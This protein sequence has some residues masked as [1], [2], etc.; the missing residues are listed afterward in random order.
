[1]PLRPDSFAL[2]CLLTALVAIGPLSTDLY[3]PALPAIAAAFQA[4][5]GEVQL[6]LSVFMG[7]FAVSQLIYG[8][9]SDRF[10]RRPVLLGGLAVYV[11]AS[12]LCLVA[13]SIEQLI[14]ARFL[15]ALGGCAGP[16]LGRA[17]V[18]D[19]FGRD[20]AA[21]A[22]S[23]MALAM[24]VAPAVGP[25]LGGYLQVWAGWTAT[26]GVL[27]AIGL[28]LLAAVTRYLPETNAY[29]NPQATRPGRLLANYALLARDPAYRG[30]VATQTCTFAGIFA[31]ISGSSFVLV[32][33]VGLSPD[34][35]GLCFAIVVVGFMVGTFLSGRLTRRWGLDR[36]IRTGLALCLAGGVP[37]ALLA[38][39]LPPS[40]PAVVA[41]MAVFMAGTGLVLPNAMA[42][43][44]GP[45]PRMAGAA[46]AL[47]GFVQMG[48]AALAGIAVGQ[49]T[50]G[51]ARA[52]AGAIALAAIGAALSYARGV[53]PHLRADDTE[54]AEPAP[55]P[56]E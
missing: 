27:A 10:G 39:T 18:R 23:Y 42:G 31:F 2:V 52:M 1:M 20:R 50:D 46:S 15:Q 55:R 47:L 8:P 19:V 33:A 30:Y 56:A 16:V 43:A 54:T 35:F 29:K 17:V 25:V 28:A 34:Q 13:A 12:G 44:I 11:V 53:R 38:L 24:A 32:E 14:A 9:L 51:T 22:L 5:S 41:P 45:F 36:M 4:D 7:G 48:G 37:M 3:L 26:F 49:L 40:V 21:Q 6:T